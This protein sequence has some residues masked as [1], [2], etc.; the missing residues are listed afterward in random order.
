MDWTTR[1]D[2]ANPR[3]RAALLITAGAA[4]L[5]AVLIADLAIP[6]LVAWQIGGAS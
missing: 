3:H 5:L 1:I 2:P 4:I 6:A